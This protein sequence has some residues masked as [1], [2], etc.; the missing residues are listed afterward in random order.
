MRKWKEMKNVLVNEYV[1]TL[2]KLH[3]EIQKH[4]VTGNYEMVA[5]LLEKCQNYAIQLGTMIEKRVGEGT[6]AVCCLEDYCEMVYQMHE[7]F[8][9][10]KKSVE[11]LSFKQ[12]PTKRDEQ[13]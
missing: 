7:N 12:K 11:L 5:E 9:Q 8:Q 2:D 3:K 10:K 4:V 13:L 1:K 6:A